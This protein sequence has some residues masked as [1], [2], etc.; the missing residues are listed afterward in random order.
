MKFVHILYFLFIFICSHSTLVAQVSDSTLVSK[1]SQSWYK[2]DS[3]KIYGLKKTKPQIIQRELG[4]EPGDSIK[5]SELIAISEYIKNRIFNTGLF[6][7]VKCQIIQ[8]E[9]HKVTF[10][11]ELKERW[12]TYVFPVLGLADRNFNEWWVERN[13]QLNRIEW[14]AYF[15]QKNMRGRNESFKLRVELGFVKKCEIFYS[16]P[17]I[18]K[19]KRFG[20]NYAIG[21]LYNKQIPYQTINNKLVYFE[22]ESSNYFMRKRFNTS[23]QLIYRSK[24]YTTHGIKI[25]YQKNQI[26]DTIAL[27]NSNYFSDQKTLQEF[28]GAAYTFKRDKRNVQYYPT[29]GSLYTLELYQLGIGKNPALN[30]S[31][32]KAAVAYYTPLSN[33]FFFNILLKGKLSSKSQP[34]Y[35]QRGL[36]YK[37]ELIRGYEY[38]VIDG[39]NYFLQKNTLR[40]LLINRTFKFLPIK[41][42]RFHHLPIAVYLKTYMDWGYVWDYSGNPGNSELSNAYLSG[43]GF[44]LD[45]V[46]YYDIVCRIEYSINKKLESG[47]FLHLN[48]AF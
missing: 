3:I 21:W 9:D 14:G 31:G 44:G 42:P 30:V 48:A 33:K 18:D 37:D 34:Y 5:A 43:G 4:I 20:I 6:L 38:Y 47:I 24:F 15:I 45:I 8:S 26:E 25:E 41:D 29:H 28:I 19:K 23:I 11:I 35:N 7:E 1:S 46:S 36:G 32:I 13:H 17:Y 39:Q 40:Y 22:D 12:F 16:I 27:L 2:I 10:I